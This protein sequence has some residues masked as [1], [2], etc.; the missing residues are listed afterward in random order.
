MRHDSVEGVTYIT[1][2]TQ[3]RG[4]QA[5]PA[6]KESPTPLCMM[7]HSNPQPQRERLL[8]HCLN[9]QPKEHPESSLPPSQ[10]Q[11]TPCPIQFRTPITTSTAGQASHKHFFALSNHHQHFDEYQNQSS[12]VSCCFNVSSR[13]WSRLKL[14]CCEVSSM[15]RQVESSVLHFPSEIVSV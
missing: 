2:T 6:K 13:R 14:G 1:V 11:H 7:S 4:L 9:Q 3:I 12:P 5:T 15:A 10:T 8:S